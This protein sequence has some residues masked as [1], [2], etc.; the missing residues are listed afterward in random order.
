MFS[1]SWEDTLYDVFDWEN[2]LA[3]IVIL[4]VI[5][6]ATH[7]QEKDMTFWFAWVL[8]FAVFALWMYWK[9]VAR[10]STEYEQLLNHIGN[11]GI[12]SGASAS[13]RG[14]GGESSS[15]EMSEVRTTG[16]IMDATSYQSRPAF[17]SSN[18]EIE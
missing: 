7:H 17:G 16:D 14:L 2:V 3:F 9:C 10:P 1:S 4:L 6:I 18:R 12:G 8:L 13:P 15:L 5:L 11:I